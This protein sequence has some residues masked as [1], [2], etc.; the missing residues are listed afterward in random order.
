[1]DLDLELFIAIMHGIE[2]I[3]IKEKD[4]INI[5]LM[6]ANLDGSKK[7]EEEYN[8]VSRKILQEKGF[9]YIALGH[10]HKTNCFEEKD[11][12]LYPGSMISLGFDE[13]GVHGMIEGSIEKNSEGTKVEYKLIPLDEKEFEEISLDI[14]EKNSLEE[15]IEAINDI[16]ENNHYKKIILIGKRNF[17]IDLAKIRKNIIN[18]R[19]L[20]IK[21][22]TKLQIDLE[23]ESNNITL[24]GLFIKQAKKAMEEGTLPKD[25]IE[26]ALEIRTRS[27]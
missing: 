5:L 26:K 1:M 20:K 17:E 8:P 24:K 3:Q 27:I 21:D 13:L 22:Q 19:I 23:K 18:P 2:N 16:P 6:H 7:G 25:Q 11:R 14:T 10:I 9:E 15:I 4:R 12:I